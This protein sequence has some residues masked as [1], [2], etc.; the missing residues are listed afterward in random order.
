[1]VKIINSHL[2]YNALP[3]K[4]VIK[5]I[6]DAG[7]YGDMD[8]GS[9]ATT[10]I[11]DFSGRGRKFQGVSFLSAI[12]F[13]FQFIHYLM[14]MIGIIGFGSFVIGSLY[15]PTSGCIIAGYC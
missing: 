1:M 4:A 14:I 5:I 11:N 8:I 7:I 12:R 15:A 9:D 3:I 10:T 2:R 6:I 13:S